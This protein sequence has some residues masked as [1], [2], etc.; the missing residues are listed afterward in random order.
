M[1]RE[2]GKVVAKVARAAD[3][4]TVGAV[5]VTVRAVEMAMAVAMGSEADAVV[6]AAMVASLVDLRRPQTVRRYLLLPLPRDA[7]QVH[8]RQHR[9]LASPSP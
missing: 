2:N 6:A 7:G 8:R 5:T 4:V 9:G 1:A 3:L